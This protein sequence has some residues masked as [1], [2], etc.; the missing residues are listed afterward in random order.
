V[1]VVLSVGPNPMISISLPFSINP[2]STRPVETVPR[3]AI[4]NT[5]VLDVRTF[6]GHQERLVKV[7]GRGR[8]ERVNGIHQLD[9]GFNSNFRFLIFECAK[10]TS[11]DD[12]D[13]VTGIS[14]S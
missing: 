6:D 10:S 1:I 2:R 7:T 14:T 9:D 12:G 8:N 5:S 13:V 3:P 4:L 11:A